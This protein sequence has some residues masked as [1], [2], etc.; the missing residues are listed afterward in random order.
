MTRSLIVQENLECSTYQGEWQ[1]YQH[2]YTTQDQNQPLMVT[3]ILQS[4]YSIY[5]I[6]CMHKKQFFCR[7]AHSYLSYMCISYL[8]PI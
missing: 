3:I 4:T 1:K 2:I 5:K 8:F 6:F 7:N